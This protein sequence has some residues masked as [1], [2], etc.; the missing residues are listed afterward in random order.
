MDSKYRSIK[1]TYGDQLSCLKSSITWLSILAV[2]C[3]NGSI[4][5]VYSFFA[6]YLGNVSTLSPNMIS[7]MLLV[8]GLANMIG[9]I[10]GGKALM[11]RANQFVVIFPLLLVMVY[12]VLFIFGELTIPM[13][14]FTSIW[15]ILAGAAG[16]INQYWI[17]SVMSEALEFGN[18]LFLA[19]T[20]LGTTLGTMLCGYLITSMNASMMFVGGAIFIIIASMFIMLRIKMNQTKQR[21]VQIGV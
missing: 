18:G 4:F 20:N 6:D 3:L 15:G 10:V 21:V 8:Y 2:V 19:A 1:T 17:T 9:N 5:G 16:N 7:V 13:M 14:V 11:K 12:I